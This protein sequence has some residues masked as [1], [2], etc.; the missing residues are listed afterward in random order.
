[1][2]S[3]WQWVGL[4]LGQLMQQWGQTSQVV[5]QYVIYDK[6]DS[7]AVNKDLGYRLAVKV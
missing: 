7:E 6:S 4:A 3:E 2:F 5:V 1:M